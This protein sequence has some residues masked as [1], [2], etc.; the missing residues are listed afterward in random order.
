MRGKLKRSYC[1]VLVLVA[2]GKPESADFCSPLIVTVAKNSLDQ[3]A[4]TPFC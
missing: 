3:S 4:R 1:V 2:L